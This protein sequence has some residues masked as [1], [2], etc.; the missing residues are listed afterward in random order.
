[1]FWK[2]PYSVAITERAGSRGNAARLK[3]ITSANLVYMY[4][5]MY[6]C[7][8]LH[9]DFAPNHAFTARSVGVPV[10]ELRASAVARLMLRRDSRYDGD[11]HL[12]RPR[13]VFEA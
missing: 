12:L 3:N 7:M 1:M 2:K 9:T 6:M 5:Y 10:L 4:M 13:R 8:W 11:T